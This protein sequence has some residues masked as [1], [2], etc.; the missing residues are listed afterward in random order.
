MP[1]WQTCTENVRKFSDLPENA[2][3]Y[4]DKVEEYLQVPGESDLAFL[5][6]NVFIVLFLVK[7]IGVGK[8]R[9]S[10]ITIQ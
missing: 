5:Y 2:K 8:G 4:V 7:W 6:I 1:G 10:I 3:K 9:E